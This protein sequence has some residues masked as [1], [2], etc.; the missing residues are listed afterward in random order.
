MCILHA[1][2]N[3]IL[4]I[5]RP[6][7]AAAFLLV[8]AGYYGVAT[9]RHKYV[10][11]YTIYLVLEVSANVPRERSRRSDERALPHAA[12]RPPSAR[13]RSSRTSCTSSR[14]RLARVARV[15]PAR[16]PARAYAPFPRV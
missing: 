6:H 1:A 16:R 12:V 11:F 15:A 4:T 14:E 7:Y 9:Y 2:K 8:V 3:A 10:L 5:G 13:S